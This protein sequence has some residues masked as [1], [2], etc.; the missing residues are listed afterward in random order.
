MSEAAVRYPYPWQE[1]QWASLD[2]QVEAGRLPH[3]VLLA[4]PAGIGKQAFARALMQRVLCLSPRL[5]Y[6]CGRC[7][8]CQLLAAGTHPDLHV[9]TGKEAGK[10]IGIDPVR[11]L[12][13]QLSQTAQQGGWKAALIV[14][15]EDMTVQAA[16]ALLKSLEEPAGRTLMVL[17]SHEPHRLLPTIRSRCRLQR[18]AVPPPDQSVEW[19]RGASGRDD[20]D[21]LLAD[22]GGRPLLALELC[23]GDY[24]EQRAGFHEVL[25]R[26]ALGELAPFNATEQLVASGLHNSTH[27]VDWFQLRVT[28]AVTTLQ[29]GQAEADAAVVM[30]LHRFYE[31]LLK[32]RGL[33][34]SPA[35]PDRRL[36]WEQL[37][38]EW[39]R[40]AA[41]ADSTVLVAT[42]SAVLS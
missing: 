17:V 13:A 30:A 19:L 26:I 20:V 27:A 21:G 8:S 42:K 24:L 18:L 25:D 34:A 40:L 28:R 36:L 41:R 5:G 15:A 23:E 29:T 11:E 10:A 22:A 2:R 38:L 9:V 32:A 6:G 4:G 12:C 16:N 3:A 37:L 1:S 33:L 31:R 14:P 35:N 39:A 7:K